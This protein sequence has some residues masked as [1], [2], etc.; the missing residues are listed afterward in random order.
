MYQLNTANSDLIIYYPDINLENF[1]YNQDE[2][3]VKMIDLEYVMIIERDLFSNSNVNNDDDENNRK[4]LNSN[5]FCNRYM[6]DFNIEQGNG[7]IISIFDRMYL[8]F[9]MSLCYITIN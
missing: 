1:V 9:S 4:I 6:P 5:K 3:R 2:R 8:L 7:I